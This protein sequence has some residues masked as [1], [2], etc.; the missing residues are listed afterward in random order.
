MIKSL[1]K[2]VLIFALTVLCWHGLYIAFG[3]ENI[4]GANVATDIYRGIIVIL[5]ICYWVVVYLFASTIPNIEARARGLYMEEM[6][7]LSIIFAALCIGFYIGLLR[8]PTV[9]F[10]SWSSV[11]GFVV[12]ASCIYGVVRFLS[13]LEKDDGVKIIPREILAIFAT[14]IPTAIFAPATPQGNWLIN[15]LTNFLPWAFGQPSNNF[16]S[17]SICLTI[18]SICFMVPI[19]NEDENNADG[20]SVLKGTAHLFAVLVL[21]LGFANLALYVANIKLYFGNSG[22]VVSL[23]TLFVNF[24][25]LIITSILAFYCY[26]TNELKLNFRNY[27]SGIATGIATYWRMINIT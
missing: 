11:I 3:S 17:N 6:F 27:L 1:F 25:P 14:I 20:H 10:I 5:V 2:Y 8:Q 23:W 4:S 7:K 12:A 26:C 9:S 22:S 15:N 13:L 18:A 21:I 16:V 24:F 19:M